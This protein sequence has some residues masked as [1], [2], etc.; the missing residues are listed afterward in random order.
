MGSEDS[1]DTESESGPV[2]S[3]VEA[4]GRHPFATGLFAILGVVGLLFSFYSYNADRV[5]SAQSTMNQSQISKNVA[6][7]DTRVSNIPGAIPES[8]NF[9]P[10]DG[11][12]DP[13]SDQPD[14]VAFER[15]FLPEAQR[16]VSLSQSGQVDNIGQMIESLRSRAGSV[17]DVPF[18]EFSLS[19]RASQRF[20]QIAPYLVIE[21]QRAQRLPDMAMLYFGERG[22][23][24]QIRHFS[25]S[26]PPQQGLYYA[27]LVDSMTGGYR[28]DI[29]FFNIEPGEVEEFFFEYSLAPGYDYTMRIGVHYKYNDQHKIY[30]VTNSFSA[31][32]PTGEVPTI[33]FSGQ[34][35]HQRY[36]FASEADIIRTATENRA[37]VSRSGL[38][39]PSKIER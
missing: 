37:W 18:F 10:L 14:N 9:M 17:S 3:F 27:P 8:D 35:Q 11:Q 2:K 12:Y 34:T 39:N 33:G 38:F 7:L 4:C 25:G 19:S 24:A 20:I 31:G 13:F 22:A 30:W 21:V 28:T 1:G 15:S 6:E 5:E 36:A 26:V 32:F 29:D 23:A 16:M